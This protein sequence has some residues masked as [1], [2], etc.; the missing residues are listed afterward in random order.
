MLGWI[1]ASLLAFGVAS[2][3]PYVPIDIPPGQ[4]LNGT[5]YSAQGRYR[6][7]NLIRFFRGLPQPVGGW[8]PLPFDVDVGLPQYTEFDGNDA[9]DGTFTSSGNDVTMVL[10]FNVDAFT[11]NT[12][13][14]LA[15][16]HGPT[17]ASQIRASV[18]I[19]S[20]DN[21]TADYRNKITVSARGGFAS[22]ICELM[23]VSGYADGK[24]H[25]LFFSYSGTTG[26]A[27]FI[28]D[29]V[30]ADDEDNLSRALTTGTLDSG[31]SSNITIAASNSTPD[32]AVTGNIGN[33]GYDDQYR[34]N[35]AD[36]MEGN[37]PKAIDESNWTEWGGSQPLFWKENGNMAANDG[38]GGNLSAVGDPALVDSLEAYEDHIPGYTRSMVAWRDSDGQR[39]LA[40]GTTRALFA[41]DGS[42]MYDIT[43]SGLTIGEEDQVLGPGYG[44]GLYG[45]ES[46]G[47][48]RTQVINSIVTEPG[49]WSL[50]TWGEKLVGVPNWE[51]QL[52]EW[53]PNTPSTVAA[54]VSGDT[55]SGSA[56]SPEQNRALVVS[57]ERHLVLIGAGD[58]GG[59]TWAAN[60]RK[61][62]WS[63][64]EDNTVWEATATNAAGDLE[65]KTNGIAQCGT[66]FYNE[67]IIWTN[68]DCHRM[69]YVG[70][71]YYYGIKSIGA[72][73]GIISQTAFTVTDNF[74]FWVGPEGFHIYDGSV[75]ELEPEVWDH[76]R[77][78][79][80]KSQ[81]SQIAVGHN[82]R[83]NEV[84]VFYPSNDS[85]VNDSYVIWNYAE[86]TW[87]A[88]TVFGGELSRSAW[89]EAL[90]WDNPIAA[91]PYGN[92]SRAAT[93]QQNWTHDTDYEIVS[94]FEPAG[95]DY[96]IQ[97]ASFSFLDPADGTAYGT[98]DTDYRVDYVTGTVRTLST[99]SFA[100]GENIECSMTLIEQSTPRTVLFNHEDGYGDELPTNPVRDVRLETGPLEIANGDNV[101]YVE[102]IMQDTGRED[103]LD[104][105]LNSNAVTMEFDVRLAPEATKETFGPYTMDTDRGYTDVR[106]TG[107]QVVMR[108]QQ[109]KNELWRVGQHRLAIKESSGR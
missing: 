5:E 39:W 107:R 48:A 61:I 49:S 31:A 91:R 2:N 109:A 82:P 34:T 64:C 37:L 11:G 26:E 13:K 106:F 32:D 99:G 24:D 54:R 102:R 19:Y 40:I 6:N 3:V 63:D 23:S 79:L 66:R 76:Y 62:W 51:G 95:V 9:Y 75:R 53:D 97:P 50:D 30:N 69:S 22:V 108:I 92:T 21:S 15:L 42:T 87:A 96:Q 104:P 28:I 70:P 59:V 38:D 72:K 57:N 45:T 84:W 8:T 68:V 56:E 43:P 98:E 52:Y 14:Y 85:T 77:D 47:T 67:I 73:A 71:P 46:Y 88:N 12:S 83:F 86:N 29:G 65:L 74:I 25:M 20:S 7:G 94:Q 58:W 105:T 36:F 35:W 4:Y 27:T 101:A 103:D 78:N 93:H 60:P 80:N 41:Y 18:R 33:V 55:G 10:R 16:V 44:S 17:G 1:A 81:S 100:T 89:C 90:I